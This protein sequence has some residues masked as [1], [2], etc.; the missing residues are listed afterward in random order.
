MFTKSNYREG[1]IIVDK[2]SDECGIIAITQRGNKEIVRTAYFGLNGIQH[3]GQQS[4]GLAVCNDGNISCYK[5]MGLITEVFDEK[6]LSLLKGEMCLGHVRYSNIEE[7]FPVNSQPM[8]VNYKKG[9]LAVAFNG[10]LINKEELIDQMLNEGL[11]FTNDSDCE[12]IAALIAR[13]DKGDIA[14][15]IL[16]TMNM[17]KGAYSIGIMTE[18]AIIGVRDPHGIRPLAIGKIDGGYV[19]A[20]ESC[21]IDM[22]DGDL[23]R[24]VQ[25]G[26]ILMIED[27]KLTSVDTLKNSTRQRAGC[28]FE[29]VYFARPDSTIDGLNAYKSREAAGQIL[30][31]ESPVLAD[32][33]IGVPDSGVAAAIGFSMSSGIQFTIGLE[34]NKYLGRTFIKPSQ[35]ERETSVKIKLNPIREVI[36]GKRIVLV[37]DSIVRGTTMRKLIETIKN[38]GAKEIHLRIAS[39]PIYNRCYLGVDTANKNDLIATSGSIESICKFLGVDSL[40]FIT[41]EGLFASLGGNKSMF[42]T[43]C[44]DGNYPKL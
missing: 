35:H 27:E 40:A 32:Y 21:A 19:F 18:K 16:K 25:P 15:A 13:Y 33:V 42:C 39:P 28:I 6:I 4:A 41:I 11:V 31:K 23:L 30:A 5:E 9:S 37:D 43:G 8:V 36:E 3:R 14:E 20:S 44:L 34:K 24:D 10:A 26:E 12:I 1:D 7:D 17:I 29:Y 2:F 22:M 38:A